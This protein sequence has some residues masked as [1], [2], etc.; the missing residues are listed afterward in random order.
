MKKDYCDISII[1]DRSGSMAIIQNDI[2]GGFNKFIKE[3]QENKSQCT[4]SLF[5]FDNIY[6][7]VFSNVD[8]QK[9]EL[10]DEKTFKPRGTTSL[11]DAIGKTVNDLGIKYSKMKEEE[12]PEKILVVIITDGQENTSKEFTQEKIKEMIDHQRNVYNWEFLY[13]GANQDSFMVANSYGIK[14]SMDYNPDVIGVANL[15]ART[16][17][18]VSSFRTNKTINNMNSNQN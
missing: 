6:E 16:S 18:N 5:Q 13:L 17:E 12:R 7:V 9:C 3:Q 14:Y 1:L 15:Y 8:L 2:I 10:L 4:I 11:L